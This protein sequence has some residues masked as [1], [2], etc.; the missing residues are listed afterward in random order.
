LLAD[1]CTAEL[2][3]DGQQVRRVAATT[4]AI[5]VLKPLL[6]TDDTVCDGKLLWWR[7]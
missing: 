5:E 1:H 2:V 7:C 6:L 4:A 3:S